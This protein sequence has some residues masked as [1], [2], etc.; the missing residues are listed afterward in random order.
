MGVRG[1]SLIAAVVTAAVLIGAT[2][3]SA[4]PS[5]ARAG[6]FSGYA[7]DAC[8]A[9]S[10]AALSAWLSSPYRALGIYIG[11]VNRACKDGNL[12]AAWVS[13]TLSA[14]WSLLPLYVGLQAPCASQSGLQKISTVAATAANQG[15]A[16]AADAIAKATSFGLPAGSPLYFDMEGYSV[17]NAACSASVKSFVSAWTTALRA[18]GYVAGVYGSAASTM[19]DVASLG[20]GLPDAGWIANW[21]GVES[22]FGDPYVSDG[23]WANHQRVHQYK[24]GHHETW[25]GST[26]NID[27]NVVD[28]PVVGGS[29]APPPPPPPVEPPAGSVGSGDSKATATWPQGAF[30]STAVVTLT[31]TTQPP[32]PS[33]YGVQLTVTDPAI[34]AP[35]T[36]FAKPVILHLLLPTGGL[37]PSWSADGTT[38]KGLPLLKAA[39][40]PAGVD[41][42]YTLDPDGTIEIQTLVP[43]FFG[44]LPDTV[45]PTQPQSFRG[46]FSKGALTL[47]WQGATDNS[48]LVASY[49]LLLDGTPVSTLA[50]AKRRVVVRSFHAAA[51]TVYRVQAVDGSGIF[52]KPS[53]P[54]VVQPTKRPTDLPKTLPRWSWS[55]L[56]WQHS[57][58]TRPK[59]APKKP[60]AWYW[61]WAAWR[62]TPFHLRS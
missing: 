41:A 31:P 60:P 11:G 49:Q 26:I 1:S 24:G 61:H 30:A 55:L 19:R 6:V 43:G 22:V 36:R 27:S 48:G 13:S 7:F 53:A 33:G 51:Q 3:S 8:T 23:V 15:R 45:P 25:A 58:G 47:S 37:T 10:S 42:G 62:L 50:G 56:T 29:T 35:V 28:G 57:G 9:P 14:G 5:A 46:H 32:A 16:A 20:T 18:E 12:S 39:A 38:W 21:N 40:L 17:N 52:G 34:A 2:G 4:A 54:V 59:A 44:L